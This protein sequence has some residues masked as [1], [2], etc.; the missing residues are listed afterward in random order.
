[1]KNTD[2]KRKKGH[3]GRATMYL[4]VLHSCNAISRDWSPLAVGSDPELWVD[5]ILWDDSTPKDMAHKEVVIHRVSHDLSN[6]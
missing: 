6:S 3:K 5:L 2:V 1:M 4:V